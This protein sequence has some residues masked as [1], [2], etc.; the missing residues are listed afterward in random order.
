MK[1]LNWMKIIIEIN[2]NEPKTMSELAR[3]LN[4]TN[5][6]VSHI[7]DE[8][9]KEGVILKETSPM[10]K[11]SIKLSLTPKGDAIYTNL[12][13][14]QKTL[15]KQE[16]KFDQPGGCGMWNGSIWDEQQI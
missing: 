1:M 9:V 3:Q 14:I 4:I 13:N 8:L 15:E 16:E 6:C 2:H 11:S 7:T 12:V 10:S 5:N